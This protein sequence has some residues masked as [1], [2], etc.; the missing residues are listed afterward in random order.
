MSEF[1]TIRKRCN[2]EKL[3]FKHYAHSD[4][5]YII[6]ACIMKPITFLVLFVALIIS[7][8]SKKSVITHDETA[9]YHYQKDG[10]LVEN[11]DISTDLTTQLKKFSGIR[12]T[13]DG[14]SA[15]IH[16]RGINSIVSSEPLMILD[17]LEVSSYADLYGMV[18][19]ASIRR[20]EVLKTPDE[21]G[22][23]GVRGANGVIRVTTK[24]I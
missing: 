18:S 2:Q 7:C 8:T 24:K 6:N 4:V 12:I 20:I 13:G 14:P 23:Y 19:R 3:N 5:T 9:G 1:K 21:I 16:I 17:G 22:I 11:P 15:T 10:Y